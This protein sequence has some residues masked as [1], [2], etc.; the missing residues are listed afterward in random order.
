[1]KRKYELTIVYSD[2]DKVKL[3]GIA[4]AEGVLEKQKV[5][6][7]SKNDIGR[8]NLAYEIKKATRGFYVFYVIESDVDAIA[9]IT[10]EY[11]LSH[12]LLRYLFVEIEDETENQAKKRVEKETKMRQFLARKASYANSQK[13]ST[14]L[15]KD[16]LAEEQAK[17]EALGVNEQHDKTAE[18]LEGANKT[19]VNQ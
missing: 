17:K 8:R 7:L 19:E 12:L 16:K 1:M 2:D 3:E 13:E 4:F 10:R 18:T 14:V 15:D 11:N 5:K 9:N 6:I